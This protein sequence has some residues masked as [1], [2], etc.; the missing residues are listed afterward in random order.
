MIYVTFACVCV[1]VCV[2]VCTISARTVAWTIILQF[3]RKVSNHENYWVIDHRL[4]NKVF[5]G[6]CKRYAGNGPCNIFVMYHIVS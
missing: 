6:G 4:G 1:C 3:M 5:L 2:C